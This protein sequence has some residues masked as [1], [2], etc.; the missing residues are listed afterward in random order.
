MWL[1]PDCAV[2]K[3]LNSV[4]GTKEVVSIWSSGVCYQTVTMVG[5]VVINK[6][7]VWSLRELKLLS[8]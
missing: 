8:A 1:L 2:G 6:L 5:R 4:P 3:V 7:M